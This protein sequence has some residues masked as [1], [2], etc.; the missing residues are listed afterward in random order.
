MPPPHSVVT[1]T[2]QFTAD[3]VKN[4]LKGLWAGKAVGP[5]GVNPMVLKA[6]AAQLGLD[7]KR[8]PVLWKTSCLVFV[9]KTPCLSCFNVYRPVT[10]T[11]H[12]VKNL[13]RLVLQQVWT[14]VS[15]HLNPFQ[16]TYQLRLGDEDAMYVCTPSTVRVMFFDP[17][18]SSA[19][20]TIRLALLHLKLTVV[21][22]HA[23]WIVDYL[24]GSV[25]LQHFLPLNV[26][27]TQELVVDLRSGRHL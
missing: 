13:E 1:T 19:F 20:D 3:Q 12:I 26:T 11:S 9:P 24:T 14:M 4:L 16:F 5:D 23:S 6:F 7:L 2:M 10:L 22:V 21:Q 17:V 15:L 8:V 27:K 25:Y 18:L